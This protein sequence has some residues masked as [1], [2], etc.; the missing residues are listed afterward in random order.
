MDPNRVSGR[1]FGETK[2]LNK[3][4]NGVKCSDAEHQLNRRTEFIVIDN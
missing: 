3:C 2:L 1:G 4:S